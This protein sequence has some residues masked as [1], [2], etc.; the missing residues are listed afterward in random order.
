MI[1]EIGL[2]VENKELFQTLYEKF[3]IHT[4]GLTR[5]EINCESFPNRLFDI[6]LWQPSFTENALPENIIHFYINRPNTSFAIYSADDRSVT[7]PKSIRERLISILEPPLHDYKF[8]TMLDSASRLKRE[9]ICL[10]TLEEEYSELIGDSTPIRQINEFISFITKTSTTLCLIRYAPGTEKEIIVRAIH[11]KSNLSKGPL[12]TVDCAYSSDK[13]LLTEIFGAE[14]SGQKSH[15]NQRGAL[16]R[17][18]GGTLVLDNIENLSDEIQNRLQVYLETHTFRRLGT[19]IDYQLKTRIIGTTTRDLESIVRKGSF[20]RELYYRFKAFEI[21]V[22]PLRLRKNDILRITKRLLTQFN[23]LYNHQVN[24]LSPEAEQKF[25]QYD[26]PGNV[27]ELTTILKRAI[28]LVPEGKITLQV[29]PADMC[30][31]DKT[32]YESE[33]LGNCSLRDI[34]R[35]HIEKALLRTRGN[36][37][38]AAELLNISRTTLRE[39]MRIF[40]LTPQ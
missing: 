27:D 32:S 39:K 15:L 40:N 16:E 34:E 4:V 20:S 2:A 13:D 26:W 35:L 23:L 22:P 37:S 14:Y 1:L 21:V 17:A 12:I 29:L 9:R 6:I 10:C 5:N 3:G 30:K 19:N 24:G 25:L 8:R 36:K 11:R 28:M 31:K 33:F 7:L 18:A 38:K